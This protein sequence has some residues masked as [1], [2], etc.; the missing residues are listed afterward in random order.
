MQHLEAITLAYAKCSCYRC[1]DTS[2]AVDM[3]CFIDGEGALAL[4]VKCLRDALSI[5]LPGS[6]R[7]KAQARRDAEEARRAATV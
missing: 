3:D 7:M 2:D 4:C 5:G 6:K 1:G